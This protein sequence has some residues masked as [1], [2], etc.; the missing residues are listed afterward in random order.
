MRSVARG[1]STV[2]RMMRSVSMM[3][4]PFTVVPIRHT[5]ELELL[6]VG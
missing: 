3:C 5:R 4:S 6:D 1:A 2:I